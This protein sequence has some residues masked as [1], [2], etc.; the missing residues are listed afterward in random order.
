MGFD[1][2]LFHLPSDL[3]R[4]GSNTQKYTKVRRAFVT[5]QLTKRKEKETKGKKPKHKL[6]IAQ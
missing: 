6:I 4:Y 1:F 5:T 2:D 3:Y